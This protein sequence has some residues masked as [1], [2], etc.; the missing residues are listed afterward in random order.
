MYVSVVN[1]ALAAIDDEIQ[2]AD[3]REGTIVEQLRSVMND[4]PPT[5]NE[6]RAPKP[7][8][9]RAEK[10][11]VKSNPAFD[12]WLESKL[13]NMFDAVAA[14]SLPPDLMKLLE[15]LDEKTRDDKKDAKS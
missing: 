6:P 9:A 12:N 13:R 3:A 8:K 11:N 14:E 15:R 1:A 10:D 4:K 7:E 5:K 2:G